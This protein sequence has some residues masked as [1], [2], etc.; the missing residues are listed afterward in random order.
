MKENNKRLNG[1]IALITGA[2]RGIGS[3]IAQR[4]SEEGAHVILISR[5]ITGLEEVDEKIRSSSGGKAKATL[6]P[7]DLS[8]G[9]EIQKLAPAIA[10]KF[11]RLD[12]LVANAALLGQMTPVA[13][14]EPK[15][16][17][18]IL[19]VNLTANWL[20]IQA[21]EPLLLASNAGRAIFLTSGVSGGRGFW[22]AYAVTKTA[23]EALAHTWAQEMEQSKL[24]IN[25]VDPGAVRTAMRALAY[26][27]EDPTT[28]KRPEE[29][30]DIFVDLAETSCKLN[31][32]K[33]S[34]QKK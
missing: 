22:G 29:I 27:G 8:K 20:L 9:E 24:C 28:L 17:N 6:V 14:I 3:A 23:L 34:A 5:S 16:W 4:Y 11:G 19:T 12:V 30:T 33:F 13:N 15:T 21:L 7:L 2:S 10:S 26:P 18:E 31:S 25:I 1:R 32:Q